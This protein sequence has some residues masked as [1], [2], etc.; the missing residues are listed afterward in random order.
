MAFAS[1]L[2]ALLALPG[3]PRDIDPEAVEAYLALNAVP[4]PATIFRAARKLEPGHRLIADPD[5]RALERYAR[6]RPLPAS[7]VAARVAGRRW[8]RRRARGSRA[9]SAPHLDA[10]APVGVLL[11]GGVDSSLI[12]ALA[13][14]RLKTFSVG[15]DVAAFDELAGARSVAERFGTDH[16]ELRLGPSDAAAL[17]GVAATLR[18]AVGRRHRA[19]LLAAGALRRGARQGRADGRGRGRAVRRLS[20]LRRRP[21]RRRCG[22]RRRGARA[23]GRALAQLVGAAEPGLPPAAAGARGRARAARTPP[24]V[25]GDVPARRCASHCSAAPGDPLA[26]LRARYAE[27]AGAEPIARLQDADIG[28]FLADDL[29]PQADRAGMAHGLEVRVPFLDPVVAELAFALPLSARVRGFETKRVLRRAAAPLLPP[30]IVRGPKRGFCTPVAAW[31]RGPLE[32]LAR[33]LL[34]P[35]RVARQGWFAPAPVSG[36]LDRHL[37][38]REDLGRPLWALIAFGLWHDAWASAPPPRPA[39]RP[40][41]SCRRPH[42]AVRPPV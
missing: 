17:E 28:S 27:T 36:L 12:T 37:E 34:S 33:D 2:K 21:A 4:A 7:R 32:E 25:Q 1:E 11:S 39:R 38:R 3:F 42:D 22:P 10:D 14:G 15:F 13:P 19:A 8:P 9:P 16:H 40:R 6:P 29:L 35:A 26:A 24:R 18:R 41:R 20:D 23:R 5:G 30:A 31:L